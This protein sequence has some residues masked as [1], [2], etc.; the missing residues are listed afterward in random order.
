M[1]DNI[2][3]IIKYKDLNFYEKRFFIFNLIIFNI[4]NKKD[5]M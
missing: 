2:K 1:F 5:L 4:W 3:N